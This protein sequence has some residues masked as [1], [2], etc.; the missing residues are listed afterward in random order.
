MIRFAALD[1]F[2]LAVLAS[3]DQDIIPAVEAVGALGKQVFVGVWPGH[4]LSR[5][6]RI[7][8]FGQV[9]FAEGEPEF[10]T[11]RQRVSGAY[12]PPTPVVVPDAATPV[13]A[14]QAAVVSP[15]PQAAIL[16]EAAKGALL[17]HVAH[18]SKKLPHVGRWYFEHNWVAGDIPRD[19]QDR[20]VLIDELVAEKRLELYDA[21][22]K[23]RSAQAIRIP[24]P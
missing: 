5:D 17:A 14:P 9:N 21:D 24:L 6:L 10:T 16:S 2:D 13:S 23:G 20:H 7:R 8:C 3:G 1:A 15:A 18:A 11:G 4:G 19:P 22:I 12:A